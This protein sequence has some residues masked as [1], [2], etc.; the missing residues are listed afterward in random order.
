MCNST[1]DDLNAQAKSAATV[2]TVAFGVE[3]AA[4]ADGALLYF[5]PQHVEEHA[6]AV[7]PSMSDR[8]AGFVLAASF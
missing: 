5:L 6:V 4:V 1:D 2:S 8:G 3:L 7:A